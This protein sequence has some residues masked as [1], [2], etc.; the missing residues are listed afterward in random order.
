[1]NRGIQR[2]F[3]SLQ[4]VSKQ[5]IASLPRCDLHFHTHGALSLTQPF[6]FFPSQFPSS[7]MLPFFSLRHFNSSISPSLPFPR[8]PFL[9]SPFSFRFSTPIYPHKVFAM[10]ARSSGGSSHSHGYTNRLATEHSPYLLQHAH[11]P[12][13]QFLFS[14]VCVCVFLLVSFPELMFGCI[15]IFYCLR[16]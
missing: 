15:S 8:F 3:S 14:S 7:S 11:N 4:A 2:S 1:M 6:S 5:H 13:I 12:V 9:S 10:A 16:H